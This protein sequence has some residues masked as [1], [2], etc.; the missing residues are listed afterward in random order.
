MIKKVYQQNL[1]D[2]GVASLISIIK[3]YNGDNTFE[4]IRY[5]TK[6]GNNGITALNLI[7]ASKKLGFNARGLRC[8][9]DDLKLLVKPLICHVVLKNGYNHYIVLYKVYDKYVKVFDPYYG[10]RKYSKDE[11][12]EIWDNI[13]IELIPYRK[14]DIVKNN[15]THILKNI[16]LDNKFK[17]LLVILISFI[18]IFLTILSNSYFKGLI[19][20]NNTYSIFIFFTLVVLI[21]EIVNLIRNKILINLEKNVIYNLNI[22]THEKMLSL[23][24][25]YFN[26]RTSGDII[27]KFDDLDYMKELLINY[28]ISLL[29]NI[30]L[31]L[32]TIIILFNISKKL[33]IIFLIFS[34]MYFLILI[35]NN[36]KLKSN[37]RLNQESNSLKNSVLVENIN[38]IYTIKNNNIKEYRHNIFLNVFNSYLKSKI[39]Y[40]NLYNNINF[41][42]NIILY[43]GIN[44]I[45]FKGINLVNSNTIKLSDLILFN[46]LIMYFIEPLNDICNLSIIFKNGINAFK[47]VNELYFVNNKNINK[48]IDNFNIKFN[49]LTFSY[50]GYKNIISNFNYKIKYKD[51]ILVIGKSGTGK[52]TLFKLL[53]KSYEVNNN[54]ISID[55]V[56]IKYI[57]VNDYITYVSQDEKIFNDTIYNN[58]VLNN[59]DN[60][61][62]EIINITG[63]DKMLIDN[64]LNINSII[65]E[66]GSNLSN[67]QKQRIILSRALLRNKNILIL[68]E[69]LNALDSN[70]EYEIMSKILNKFSDKTIIYISHSS[71]CK[72]LFNKI[73]NFDN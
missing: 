22:N 43:I 67:G 46:S 65:E 60:N 19:D 38:S 24:I 10:V 20:S 72:S 15:N 9:Y 59:D 45:L 50:D 47:R 7:E 12:L 49:N 1:K 23:P 53:N 17:Y 61:I 54:M 56:D 44:I 52:S 16:I 66:N 13:V 71:V 70:D 33:T 18:G 35:I 51:K 14:L 39:N 55:N 32:T 26:S 64:K 21:K 42:K 29:I 6:C 63:L 4:N 36:N 73:L 5:L 57:N 68:D 48:K 11:F 2:C 27:T 34:T 25:Y 3:Y 62:D 30:I 41:I 40:E 37:I 28:P 31:M 69:S 58:I 8:N